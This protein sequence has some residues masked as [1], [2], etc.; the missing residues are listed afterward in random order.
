M[1]KLF[2]AKISESDVF[3]F[4][5][6]EKTAVAV[7]EKASTNNSKCSS[8][9]DVTQNHIQEDGVEFLIEKQFVGIPQVSI[10]MLNGSMAARESHYE[11]KRRSE[12]SWWSD[13]VDGSKEAWS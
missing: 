8:I 11:T 10:F 1:I 6:N 3:C 7:I 4:A 5:P 9:K 13:K 12:R 2:K